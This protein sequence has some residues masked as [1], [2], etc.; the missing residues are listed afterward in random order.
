V[1]R[2]AGISRLFHTVVVIGASMG[3]GLEVNP[4]ADAGPGATGPTVRDAGAF[5]DAN[6]D[7]GLPQ[8][9]CDCPEPGQFV[10]PS[11]L[12]GDTPVE[13]HCPFEDGVDCQCE[14]TS[15]V[16]GPDQCADPSYYTCA[17]EPDAGAVVGDPGWFQYAEC[18]CDPT[19][20]TTQAA[21]DSLD[22]GLQRQCTQVGCFSALGQLDFD[23]RCRPPLPLIPT[24]R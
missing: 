17:P 22:A 3:C 21:C 20:P 12:G 16:A 23:C 5:A 14:P 6:V 8:S 24:I 2:K 7:A 13:G 1:N 4:A 15:G 10:C 19:R 11:C 9:V 18:W